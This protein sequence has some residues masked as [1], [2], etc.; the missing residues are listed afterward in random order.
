MRLFGSE[1]L[2][3]MFNALG[4][5]ENEQI[6]HKMLSNAIE[7]AQKKIEGN[8]FG[9]RKNLLEYDQ[10]MNEQREIMYAER[11]R[12]LD[13]ESMRNSI[14]DML[15]ATVERIINGHIA[16]EVI[17]QSWDCAKLNQELISVVPMRPIEAADWQG[18]KKSELLE[19]MKDIAVKAYETK[20]KEFPGEEQVRE[21][22]RIILMKVIDR[23]WMNHIDDMD[24]LRQGIGLQAYGNRN[25]L[26]E[27]KMQG[28]DMFDNM[29]ANIQ[30]DTVKLMLHI[31]IEEKV[32]RE[33]VAKVT[34]TNKDDSAQRAPKKRE[35][36]K[37]Y[38]NDPCPCGSGKKY[39]QCCMKK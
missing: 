34:G 38:P 25:P 7:R 23:H 16:E 30:E 35:N 1:K 20:E 13:G 3:S 21:V 6:E 24:Q 28:Y 26:V 29:I 11:R 36:T 27:Y 2:I 39:K 8:N 37:V 19:A 4:V 14:L 17:P 32:E 22:E 31:R 5:P 12:V 15:D 18:R 10:V 33:E 9:I